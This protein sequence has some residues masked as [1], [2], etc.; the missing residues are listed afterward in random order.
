MLPTPNNFVTHF[1]VIAVP[2]L[3]QASKEKS[4]F[5]IGHAKT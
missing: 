2:A 4:K 5:I 1:G 3:Q